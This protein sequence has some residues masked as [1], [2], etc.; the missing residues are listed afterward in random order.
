MLYLEM[1]FLRQLLVNDCGLNSFSIFRY[2]NQW[3]KSQR[4]D[5]SPLISRKPWM[6][7]QAITF[8][9]Q[10]LTLGCSVFEYGGGG[11]T[12]YFLD[13]GATV[14]TVEHDQL[15][16]EE[17]NKQIHESNLSNNWNGLMIKPVIKPIGQEND[18]SDPFL[19]TSSDNEFDLF[20]FKD[21]VSS[22]DDYS[23]SSFDFVVIDGRSRPSCVK[24]SVSKVKIGGFLVLDNTERAYYLRKTIDYLDSFNVVLD[25]FGPTPGLPCFT[26]TMIFQRLE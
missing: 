24:H 6:T 25:K 16:F 7:F 10:N 20:W 8:L 5:Q 22:I 13:K 15:W 3:K 21:Y 14:T 4:K 11:S 12:L 26:K 1:Q 23:D 19:Y 2:L 17:L 18:P 9:E